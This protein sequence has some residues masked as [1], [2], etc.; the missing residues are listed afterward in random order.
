MVKHRHV[1]IFEY[2]LK[3]EIQ[4]YFTRLEPN[5]IINT[6]KFPLFTSEK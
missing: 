5:A 3:F 6:G 4:D 2:T 1:L